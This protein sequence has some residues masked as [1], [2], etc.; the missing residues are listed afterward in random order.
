MK[1]NSDI[2][3]NHMYAKSILSNAIEELE[4]LNSVT[5]PD[6]LPE[7]I[8]GLIEAINMLRELRWISEDNKIRDYRAMQF[9]SAELHLWADDIEKFRSKEDVRKE[10]DSLKKSFDQVLDRLQKEF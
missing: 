2:N 3:F 8:S 7:I 4:D 10:F 1:E 9:I 6:K 5:L